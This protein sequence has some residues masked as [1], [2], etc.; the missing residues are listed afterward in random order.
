MVFVCDF[1]NLLVSLCDLVKVLVSFVRFCKFPFSFATEIY[2]YM[3]F[4]CAAAL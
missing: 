2:K 4:V 3:A 1:V